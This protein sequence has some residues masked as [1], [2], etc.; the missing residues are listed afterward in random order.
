MGS[1]YSCCDK[2]TFHQPEVLVNINNNNS[3]S[4]FQGI[5][6]N[7]KKVRTQANGII[8]K[9]E[10]E[11]EE[12]NNYRQVAPK[13][14]HSSFVVKPVVYQMKKPNKSGIKRANSA[15]KTANEYKKYLEEKLT[16]F[17]KKN[18]TICI[19]KLSPSE[20]NGLL[21]QQNQLGLSLVP[22]EYCNSESQRSSKN[23]STELI[24]GKCGSSKS[25]CD[26]NSQNVLSPMISFKKKAK[27]PIEVI[28]K[29]FTDQQLAFIKKI[30]YDEEI[31]IDEMDESTM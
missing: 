5:D 25:I 8:L 27:K 14:N 1:S 30:L 10:E 12:I 3:T 24:S 31:L 13:R 22:N 9:F 28:N 17:S 19:K 29:P 23:K 18:P 4:T 21:K 2:K 26:L 16:Q 7:N 11:Q 15:L 6:N 20:Y